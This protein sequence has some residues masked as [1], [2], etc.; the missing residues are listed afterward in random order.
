VKIRFFLDEDVHAELS[1]VLRKRGFDVLHAQELERK[2]K[3][4]REQL[5]FA[6]KEKRCI[7]SFNVRDFVI[8]HNQFLRENREHEGIIV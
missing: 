6:I 7:F 8:L 4:D 2:G 1:H 5:D 3:T